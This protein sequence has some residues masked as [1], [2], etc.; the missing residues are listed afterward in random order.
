[1]L[2]LWCAWSLVAHEL[3][4]YERVE[5]VNEIAEDVLVAAHRP[6][7]ALVEGANRLPRVACCCVGSHD[8]PIEAEVCV[9]VG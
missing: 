2:R 4:W 5:H 6:W 9:E 1:M 8:L 7:V 3:Y